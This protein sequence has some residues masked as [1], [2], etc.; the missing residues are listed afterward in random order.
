LQAVLGE[1]EELGATLVAL[2]PQTPEHNQS[3][4][5]K[6]ALN[7]HLLSDP[8]NAY[9]AE[10]GLRFRVPDE[11]KKVYS[12]FGLDLPKYNGDDSWTL[13]IPARYVID[14]GGIIRAAD[15]DVDY[16]RRPEASKT[17]QDLRALA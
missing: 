1:L 5:A 17:V 8:G 2:T 10:L 11:L 13:P 15:I 14:Q 4:I 16:T 9:A 12:G 3:M 6:N 7:F